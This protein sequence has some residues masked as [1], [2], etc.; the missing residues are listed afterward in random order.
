MQQC[1][2]SNFKD[3]ILL[4]TL[5]D[6]HVYIKKDKSTPIILMRVDVLHVWSCQQIGVREEQA[7]RRFIHDSALGMLRRTPIIVKSL[8]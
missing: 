4:R 3:Q 5:F 1:Y 2:F 7:A 8:R 6:R